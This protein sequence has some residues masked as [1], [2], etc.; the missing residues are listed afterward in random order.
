MPHISRTTT[1]SSTD[2]D[3]LIDGSVTNAKLADSSMTSNKHTIK[4]CARQ[5]PQRRAR[6]CSGSSSAALASTAVAPGVLLGNFATA[7]C[8][9]AGQSGRNC[10]LRRPPMARCGSDPLHPGYCTLDCSVRRLG[11]ISHACS[12]VH[13]ILSETAYCAIKGVRTSLCG[14]RRHGPAPS[15]PEIRRS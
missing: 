5:L 13:R 9:V 15:A 10:R 12:M 3:R 11:V 6:F 8:I 4:R 1:R 2:E 7:L 14:A